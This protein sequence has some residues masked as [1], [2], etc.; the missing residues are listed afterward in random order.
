MKY[1]GKPVEIQIRTL[2]QHS[3]A[4]LSEKI[5]DIVDPAIK[6]GVGDRE[7]IDGLMGLANEVAQAESQELSLAILEQK[8]SAMLL[9]NGI[10]SERK[11]EL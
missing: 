3:W 1:N 10:G 11:D 5:A 6:Y 9:E 7:L 2:L 8:V 4:E